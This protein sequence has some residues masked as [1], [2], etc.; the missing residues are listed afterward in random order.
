MWILQQEDD[1]ILYQ[2]HECKLNELSGSEK[3]Y[4]ELLRNY[5]QLDVKIEKSY[6]KWSQADP[7]FNAA[8]KQFYGIRI[9]KQDVTE[10]MFSFICSSNNHITRYIHIIKNFVYRLA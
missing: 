10:N 8:A 3:Y 2:V 9:L 1:V 4:N 5:F 6:E 7:Y